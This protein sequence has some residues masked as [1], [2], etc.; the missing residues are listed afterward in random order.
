VL[1]LGERVGHPGAVG[2]LERDLA[3]ASALAQPGEESDSHL[4]FPKA[5]PL[6]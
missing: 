3:G 1:E 6:H 2:E 4:H 5:T